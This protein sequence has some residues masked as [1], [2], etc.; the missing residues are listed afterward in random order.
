MTDNKNRC[1]ITGL[2]VINAIGNNV[3]ES[4][5][6]ALKGVSGIKNTN[7]VDTKDCYA[8][9]AAE[10]NYKEL[11]S[12]PNTEKMDRVS[13]LCI[14]ATLEALEDAKLKDF[15]GSERVSVI[16][17]S[18]VGG[19]VSIDH[20]YR[21]DKN[22]DDVLKMPISAVAANVAHYVH[23]GGV[24]T[25]IGNACAAGTISI[26]YAC[27]L[28]RAGKADVVIAGGADAFASVPYAGFLA[29]HA[30]DSNPCSPFNHC[31]G[32][33]LGEG[34][35]AVIVESYEHAKARGAKA[36]CEVLGSGVSSDAHHITAPREDG[37]GQMNAINWAINTSGVKKNEI[38]YINAHGT[39]TAKNDNAEFLSLH[40]VFDGENDNLSVSS[41]KAMVGHCLGAAG[42]IEAVFSIKAL[43]ENKVP[44]TLGYSDED[45]VTLKDKA[46]KIDFI[47]NNSHDKNLDTVMS[48]SFA[49]G[50]N[51]ASII[52]SKKEGDVNTK[53]DCGKVYVTGLGMVT[54]L[55]SGK[56]N[57]VNAINNGVSID[58]ENPRSNASV[59]DY[60]E[61]GLK[62]LYRKH[63]NL[64]HLQVVSG[65][66]AL[67]D[68]NITVTDDNATDIGIVVGSSEGALGTCLEFTENIVEKG[69]ANG[70]A[71]KFPNTVYNA[72]GGYL[73]I[74]SG[75]K[76][77]NVT[78]TNG[79]QSG[80]QSV[81][82]ATNIIRQGKENYVLATGTDENIDYIKEVFTKLDY[83]ADEVVKPFAG[84]DKFTL[85]DG[86]ITVVLENDKNAKARGAKKYAEVLGYGMAT[87]AVEYGKLSGTN[88]ALKKAI[89]LAL[90]DANLTL[91]DIDTVSGFACGM[92]K[93]DTIELDV[94]NDLF[95]DNLS[96]IN[97]LEVKDHVGEARAA[98]A[99]L[100][101]AHASLMLAGE[102][103]SDNGYK[104][105]NGSVQQAK[106]LAKDMKN[107]LCIS[108][109]I[110]GTYTA[111]II[112]K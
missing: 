21:T 23:A 75:I 17:G 58:N 102:I 73:S 107:V 79:N 65:M 12:I 55:A 31:S 26:A 71:F 10:V 109:A 28:I 100:S 29:L 49:F 78:V 2:G 97:L 80:L 83:V 74:C 76:G 67:K 20:Y 46:G 59:E 99:S 87:K 94:L 93:V 96:N 5:N 81:A 98:A 66:Q 38:G 35:G 16:M 9:L 44:A 56:A 11:D 47:P 72:A 91:A 48:N 24:V 89:E 36:Y 105:T 54:P 30:L 43:T 18:C 82:Y 64:S 32:I 14:K 111:V 13:K 77:Y 3:E 84:S 70:S 101:L 22:K 112:T 8:T 61:F 50:G 68:A 95:G 108:Y 53:N 34:S 51:N 106:V 52:F 40:T 92:N 85:S 39:G 88:D 33:T 25:N 37:E 103:E 69:C 110:G 60:V 63:D 4:W 104:F 7:T 62:P 90:E 27:D 1:V 15:S 41:T 45:L 57:Y 42:A 19:A 6:N 86:S